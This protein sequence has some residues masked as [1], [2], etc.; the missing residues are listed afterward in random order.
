[1]RHSLAVSGWQFQHL[2]ALSGWSVPEGERRRLIRALGRPPRLNETFGRPNPGTLLELRRNILGASNRVA[3]AVLG[4]LSNRFDLV[5]AVLLATHLGGH[6]FWDLSQLEDGRLDEGTRALLTETLDQV[7]VE[8]DAALGRITAAL[9]DDADLIVLS[10][11][12]MDVNRSRADLLPGML[13]AVLDGGAAAKRD[14]WT[15]RARIP[16]R[17]RAAVA[18]ALPDPL[19]L[20]V[21]ERLQ[22]G[23]VDW[24]RV[25][26]FAAPSDHG[27]YVRLNLRGRER[28]GIVNPA[29]A[30]ELLDEL[31]AGLATFRDLDGGPTMTAVDRREAVVERGARFEELPDLILRWSE[32]PATRLRGVW[33]P[34]FGEVQRLG[35]GSGRAGN[36]N[37]DAWAL[38]V[39]RRA[40]R[41]EP[42]R[43]PRLVDIA[44]T[45]RELC[46]VEAGLRG[47][48]LLSRA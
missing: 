14:A 2:M 28:E 44:A 33:S 42:S 3:D 47:E 5:W 7:Y 30:D 25:R 16:T 29:E 10:P 45:V 43:P 35:V 34:E 31:A 24:S 32:A 6:W 40:R 9:P 23:R 12:G 21:S 1:M 18:K 48:P 39:P 4:S 15:L 11:L 26:A 38:L 8:A 27:G 37:D 46:G 20:A 22:F 13:S 17:V 41:A 19:A 36:H